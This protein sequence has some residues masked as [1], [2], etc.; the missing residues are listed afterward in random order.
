[1]PPAI[2]IAFLGTGLMGAAMVRR[3]LAAGHRPSVWN[4]SA[5]RLAPLVDA[6]ARAAASP[7]AAAR[8]ADLVLA[9]LLDTTAVEQ[10][11]FGPEGIA[12]LPRAAGAPRVFV[13][14]ASIAPEATREFAARLAE[15]NGTHWVDAPVSGGVAGTDAGTLAVMCG[16]DP[17]DVERAAPA[18]AAY[19]GRVTRMGPVGAGQTTKLANQVIV[20]AAIVAINEAVR[21]AQSGGVDASALPGALAGGWADSKP[22]Q[23]FVPRMLDA[24]QPPIGAS[25]TMLKDLDAALAQARSAGVPTPLAATVAEVFRQMRAL[26]LGGADP[27]RMV[28][29]YVARGD[30]GGHR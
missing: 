3:L 14:H 8:D 21:L 19:A 9:C 29:L 12:S 30:S 18:I 4:R 10:V 5:S 25:D 11:V 1:M 27:A 17:P 15:A 2:R 22:L 24:A 28:G 23:V 6:G 13:D 20:A 7:A 26:G 16:G